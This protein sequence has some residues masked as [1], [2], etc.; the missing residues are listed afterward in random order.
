MSESSCLEQFNAKHKTDTPNQNGA[1][2]DI[3]I[4]I[5]SEWVPEMEPK[6]QK[7]VGWGIFFRFSKG[8]KASV[9]AYIRLVIHIITLILE[10]FLLVNLRGGF[11]TRLVVSLVSAAA[12]D[13]LWGIV[14]KDVVSAFTVGEREA[15]WI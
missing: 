1:M 10:I 3:Q 4:H 7:G 2:Q 11:I 9:I 13:N 6:A 12:F 8:P 14:L 15:R 5:P